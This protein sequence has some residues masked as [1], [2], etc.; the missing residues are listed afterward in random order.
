LKLP[1][2]IASVD[3]TES[4][5]LTP[6][7][8]D[9]YLSLHG[10]TIQNRYADG[11]QSSP[12]R[13]EGVLRKHLDA[14]VL[15][16]TA[17]KDGVPQVCLRTCIRPP[18]LMRERLILPQPD[19]HLFFA[20]LELPAG[21]IE[22]EDIGEIGLQRRAAAE[23]FEEAGYRLKPSAFTRLGAAP[24]ITPGVMAERCFFL[25]ACIEDMQDRITP[26]GD[27]SPVEDGGDIVWLPLPDA[28]AMCDRGEIL[29]MKTE[30]GLRRLAGDLL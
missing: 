8:T 12:Y 29:D 22:P 26:E 25:K 24:F 13:Y 14:V 1:G 2:K 11:S 16:L 17:T 3:I 18:L 21:L 23:A 19:D 28:I 27:G 30:L 20:L 4:R 15:V 6:T 10:L 7:E 9:A 5:N